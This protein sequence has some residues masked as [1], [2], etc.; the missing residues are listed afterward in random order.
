MDLRQWQNYELKVYSPDM[1][2]KPTEMQILVQKSRIR[3]VKKK[4]RLRSG[5]GIER[6]IWINENEMLGLEIR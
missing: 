5:H 3:W 2:M 4:S 1:G 6:P